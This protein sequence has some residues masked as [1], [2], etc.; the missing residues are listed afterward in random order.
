MI[1]TLLDFIRLDRFARMYNPTNISHHIVD[2][3]RWEAAIDLY[4]WKPEVFFKAIKAKK[5]LQ[6][7]PCYK[8][9]KNLRNFWMKKPYVNHGL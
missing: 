1:R 7:I 4:I 5:H 2:G 6:K 9:Y 3:S 8:R